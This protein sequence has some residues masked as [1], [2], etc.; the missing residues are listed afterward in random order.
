MVNGKVEP[1]KIYYPRVIATKLF[2]VWSLQCG[3][4]EKDFSKF[5]VLGEVKCPYCRVTNVPNFSP[6]Y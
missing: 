3:N 5:S 6:A 4:C 1:K 2:K